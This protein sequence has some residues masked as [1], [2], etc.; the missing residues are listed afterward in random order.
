MIFAPAEHCIIFT[1][2][3]WNE[4]THIADRITI[5]RNGK[6]LGTFPEMEESE[7]VSLMTGQHV[8]ARYP[9]RHRL[10]RAGRSSKSGD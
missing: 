10:G 2:H 7:A 5:F 3:R 6:D 4:I 9:S 8:D 1:S